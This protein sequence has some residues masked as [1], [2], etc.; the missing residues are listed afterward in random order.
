MHAILIILLSND[1]VI[2][3]VLAWIKGRN[4][5]V[6]L[7]RIIRGKSYPPFSYAHEETTV[8]TDSRAHDF[9]WIRDEKFIRHIGRCGFSHCRPMRRGCRCWNDSRSITISAWRVEKTST[10]TPW[11]DRFWT[12]GCLRAGQGRPEHAVRVRG[13]SPSVGLH[14]PACGCPSHPTP[15]FTVRSQCA[16]CEIWLFSSVFRMHVSARS[17]LIGHD[18]G[19]TLIIAFFIS[20]QRQDHVFCVLIIIWDVIFLNCF[21]LCSLFKCLLSVE[22]SLTGHHNRTEPQMVMEINTFSEEVAIF[23]KSC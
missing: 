18:S 6:L 5:Q 4:P 1:L 16:I 23:V 11:M 3:A 20:Q 14:R 13:N 21:G 10:H 17:L 19:M 8:P 12:Q 22:F 9:T 15:N 7:L 2:F